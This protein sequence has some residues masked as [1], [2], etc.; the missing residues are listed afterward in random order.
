MSAQIYT[1]WHEVVLEDIAFEIIVSYTARPGTP[2]TWEDPGDAP[3]FEIQS[4]TFLSQYGWADFP[5]TSDD[6]ML[7]LSEIA[8]QHRFDLDERDPDE[9]RDSQIESARIEKMFRNDD[10]LID[11]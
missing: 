2:D 11:F 1:H 8:D 3:E 9:W 6:H 4:A 10:A 7:I 5:L